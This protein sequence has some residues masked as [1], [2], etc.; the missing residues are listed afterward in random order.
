M[1]NNNKKNVILEVKNLK[2]Y[3]PL[4][5]DLFGRPQAYLK[6]VDNVSFTLEAGKTI[7]VVGESGCGKTTL[8]RTILQLY[9][10]TGGKTLYYGHTV[11]EKMPKYYI[12]EITN[13]PK[14]KSKFNSLMNKLKELLNDDDLFDLSKVTLENFKNKLSEET[15]NLNSLRDKCEKNETIDKLEKV[16]KALNSIIEVLEHA[17]ESTGGKILSTEENTPLFL[18]LESRKEMGLDL[19]RLSKKN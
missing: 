11:E 8:G 13:L 19:A 1:E 16:T 3:F 6:A 10:T 18:E 7:G 5:K 15:F 14:Y 9:D 2:K 4:N 12:K 17:S